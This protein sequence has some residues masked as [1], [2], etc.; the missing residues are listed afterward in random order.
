[1][2]HRELGSKILKKLTVDLAE[3]A[4]VEVYPKMEGYQ[5]FTIFI[6]K[7]AKIVEKK[8]AASDKKVEK[9]AK[10]EGDEKAEKPTEPKKPA[11]KVAAKTAVEP[12]AD[13]EIF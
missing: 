5:M 4:D 1:M 3:L 13:D 8:P 11:K 9:A 10:P 7:K 12:K 2:T 6:P